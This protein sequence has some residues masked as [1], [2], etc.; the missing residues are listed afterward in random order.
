MPGVL[1]LRLTIYES[2]NLLGPLRDIAAH[3]DYLD[4]T[5]PE[6]NYCSLFLSLLD[7]EVFAVQG[8]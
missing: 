5:R 2:P 4:F 8:G 1:S 7:K 6:P 3:D